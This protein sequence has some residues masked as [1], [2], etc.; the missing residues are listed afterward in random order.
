MV[1]AESLAQGAVQHGQQHRLG[2]D[3]S[4]QL[5]PQVGMGRGDPGDRVTGGGTGTVGATDLERDE[6]D[7]LGAQPGQLPGHLDRGGAG[8]A[9]IGGPYDEFGAP[10]HELVPHRMGDL[11]DLGIAVAM[12]EQDEGRGRHCRFLSP[13]AAG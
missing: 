3:R 6:D 2:S 10:G 12:G 1:V 8:S 11:R 5:D 13:R 9:E 7:F 4:G